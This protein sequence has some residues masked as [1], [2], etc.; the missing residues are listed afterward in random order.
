MVVSVVGQAAAGWIPLSSPRWW[1]W[2]AVVDDFLCF[3]DVCGMPLDGGVVI[4]SSPSA[5]FVGLLGSTSG[6]EKSLLLLTTATPAGV[7]FLLG[8][9]AMALIALP[10]IEHRGKP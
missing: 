6:R 2:W 10:H 1:S 5:R 8:G 3:S 7:V 9:V 4:L